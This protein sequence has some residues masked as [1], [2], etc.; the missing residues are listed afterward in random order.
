MAGT[1]FMRSPIIGT[2]LPVVLIALVVVAVAS[3]KVDVCKKNSR[4]S[5]SVYVDDD[6]TVATLR[7]KLHDSNFIQ[8]RGNA[9]PWLFV[10]SGGTIQN[11]IETMV[12]VRDIPGG[13]GQGCIV[14]MNPNG[15][16]VCRTSDVNSC[17]DV[18]M[19]P[20]TNLK[21]LRDKLSRDEGLPLNGCNDW[22]FVSKRASESEALSKSAFRSLDALVGL[23]SESDVAVNDVLFDQT[24]HMVN[25][26]NI[27]LEE[28]NVVT[29]LQKYPIRVNLETSLSRLR[30]LLSDSLTC[31]GWSKPNGLRF[32]ENGEEK[33]RVIN[34]NLDTG[35]I[36][37]PTMEQRISG[38]VPVGI[39]D[40]KTSTIGHKT[41]TDRNHNKNIDYSNL[42]STKVDFI[43]MQT[44]AFT[45]GKFSVSVITR[46]TDKL[47]P[48]MLR[49]VKS[50]TYRSVSWENVVIAENETSVVFRIHRN[51]LQ[52]YHIDVYDDT[53]T[54]IGGG[55]YCYSSVCNVVKYGRT[56]NTI[57]LTQNVIVSSNDVMNKKKT[58]TISIKPLKRW[59]DD[60]S[61]GRELTWPPSNRRRRRHNTRISEDEINYGIL[62]EGGNAREKPLT[63]W[64]KVKEYDEEVQV[65]F[66]IFNFRSKEI[67]AKVF[68]MQPIQA[69]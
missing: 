62:K 30:Q 69:F 63:G 9:D 4:Q 68:A 16:K 28:I 14:I 42:E 7:Q 15:F 57:L 5:V 23:N 39:D 44:D 26:Y 53:R 41:Y 58:I 29:G 32:S 20:D 21:A 27:N 38:D 67:A 59:E 61:N 6:M 47:K 8:E 45:Y 34:R 54:F 36:A 50:T 3:A 1:R 46:D 35:N 17:S 43:G 51:D 52:P 64:V 66:D 18:S 65:S 48:L 49:H 2:P 40:E 55:F 37:P 33:W 13:R 12:K 11:N 25:F 19:S 56:E 60:D 22:R 10:I 24:V 31:P